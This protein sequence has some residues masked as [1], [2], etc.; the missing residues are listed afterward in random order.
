MAQTHKDQKARLTIT[1]EDGTQETIQ[2]ERAIQINTGE[3][4]LQCVEFRQ[5]RAGGWVMAFTAA[6]WK[7]RK[8]T[9]IEAEKLPVQQ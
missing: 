4:A 3:D 8:F 9:K 1:F 5:T 6:L 2:L 7:G